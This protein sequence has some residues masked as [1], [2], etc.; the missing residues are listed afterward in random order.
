MNFD[1]YPIV[2]IILL[3]MFLLLLVGGDTAQ[4]IDM[5]FESTDCGQE[6][7]ERIN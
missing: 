3:E 4:S 1:Q 6:R 7:V 2:V 5:P